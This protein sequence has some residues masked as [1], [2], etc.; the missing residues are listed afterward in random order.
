M[1][2]R[3]KDGTSGPQVKLAKCDQTQ[4]QL[5]PPLHD[6][7]TTEKLQDAWSRS[8]DVETSCVTLQAKPF[9][10]CIIK[11]YLS[12]EFIA[13]LETDLS[14]LSFN[15]KSNDLYSFKQ[16]NDLKTADSPS[17][18]AFASLLKEKMKDWLVEVTGIP[19]NDEVAITSSIYE[20]TDTL[21]CHDDELEERRIAFILYITP[22]SWT[23]VDGG[24]LDLFSSS[25]GRIKP[26]K[27]VKS[28]LPTRNSL[29]FFEVT[30]SS[31]H[32]VAEVLATDKR[33]LSMGG[34]FHGPPLAR[35]AQSPEPKVPLKP[36][37]DGYFDMVEDW[38]NPLYFDDEVL[39]RIQQDFED[40]SEILLE[41]FLKEDKVQMITT[42]LQAK[43]LKWTQTGPFNKRHYEQADSTSM[44]ELVQQVAKMFQSEAM[45]LLLGRLTGLTLQSEDDG[46]EDSHGTPK[47]WGEVR[48]WRHGY[49]T[50]MHDEDPHN[51]DFCL[52]SMFYLNALD[53]K[54]D[55]GGYVS[56]IAKGEDEE[57][58]TV[59]PKDNALALV[60]RDSDTLRF[61][62][63]IN[64]RATDRQ[65]SGN[66][67]G[68]F[69]EVY[70][71]YYE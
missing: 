25:E 59:V 51:N 60:Y 1:S 40:N 67:D 50:L 69:F 19:L 52:D 44:S 68:S 8:L 4:P 71:A 42:A 14:Q 43:D 23:M 70:N 22:P 63:Y 56:Y 15:T 36:W 13:K 17:I 62:K 65:T 6:G 16:T 18:G 46:E 39:A 10:H 5:P 11:N 27:V 58:L 53:W 2:K 30:A 48:R 64:T 33:R 9:R 35:P 31:F 20:H 61:V 21:L 57:L 54:S 28:L 37:T 3:R 38:V 49:Y 34:W 45:F 47:C 55:Y 12:E 7:E 29:V 24:T 26:E 41:D 66:Q 32:Q